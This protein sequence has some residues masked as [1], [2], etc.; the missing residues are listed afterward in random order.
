MISTQTNAKYWYP[1]G[2]PSLT[3]PTDGTVFFIWPQSHVGNGHPIAVYRWNSQNQSWLDVT[4]SNG[5]S[6]HS[7]I[8]VEMDDSFNLAEE[9]ERMVREGKKCECGAE[10]VGS[11][12]HS[13]WCQKWSE[14]Y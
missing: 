7:F 2:T 4:F 9:F 12:R 1:D 6:A 10:A 13:S 3:E 5:R 14:D 11:N 8:A